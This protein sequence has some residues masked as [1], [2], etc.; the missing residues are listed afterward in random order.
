MNLE[1]GT[2]YSYSNYIT[3]DSI[4][5]E[6]IEVQQPQQ[7]GNKKLLNGKLLIEYNGVYYNT[8]GQQVQ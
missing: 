2:S 1:G 4:S 8:L 6:L 7:L 5:A 3:S